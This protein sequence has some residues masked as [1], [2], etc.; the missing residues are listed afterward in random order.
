MWGDRPR[1]RA[2]AT[3]GQRLARERRV[4]A[5]VG[6]REPASD[7]TV[8]LRCRSAGVPRASSETSFHVVAYAAPP[9]SD[10]AFATSP[11]ACVSASFALAP[12]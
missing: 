3:L 4:A 2:T 12:D 1:V 6:R 10:S 5:A 7:T 11:T 8:W 9:S